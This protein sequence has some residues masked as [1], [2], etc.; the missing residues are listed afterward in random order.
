M[1]RRSERT[2]NASEQIDEKIAGLADWRGRELA[3]LRKLINE[4]DSGLK[5]EWKWG[6][7]VW[8]HNGLVCAVAAFKDHLKVNFF[9][10]RELRDPLKL[11]NAGL[12]AKETRAIDIHEGDKINEPA[13]K[14]LV[15]D[16]V[17]LND[18]RNG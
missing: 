16:A 2:M 12:D 13:L 4:A 6:T 18:T 8:T 14:A 7:P 11:F 15:R 1:P 9:R 10:G 5:E 17:R 3:K